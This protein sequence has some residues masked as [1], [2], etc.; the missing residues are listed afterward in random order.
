MRTIN[1]MIQLAWGKGRVDR[2]VITKNIPDGVPLA[3]FVREV[4]PAAAEAFIE[5]SDR[6]SSVLPEIPTSFETETDRE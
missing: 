3:D 5:A 6:F 1:L 4:M 2:I